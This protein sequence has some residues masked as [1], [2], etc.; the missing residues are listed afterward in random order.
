MF[1]ESALIPLLKSLT[2]YHGG[3]LL[4]GNGE[5]DVSVL[6]SAENARF[7]AWGFLCLAFDGFG[8]Q[9]FCK[10]LFADVLPKSCTFSCE[11]Q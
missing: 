3:G 2:R 1:E 4:F 9:L 7:K 5:D 10:K 8:Y 11:D 6:E